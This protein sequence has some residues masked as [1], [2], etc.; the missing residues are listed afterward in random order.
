MM[1][2]KD[3]WSENDIKTFTGKLERDILDNRPMPKHLPVKVQTKI[4]KEV[5]SFVA[6]VELLL[7]ENKEASYYG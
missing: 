7:Q 6:K 2:I 4:I 3:R 1:D 5:K